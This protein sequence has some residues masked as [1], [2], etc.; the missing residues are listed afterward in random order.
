MQA[1]IKSEPIVPY[2]SKARALY[3]EHGVSTIIIVGGESPSLPSPLS[4]PPLL[5]NYCYHRLRRL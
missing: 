5:T 3:E 1:L 4:K 2:V